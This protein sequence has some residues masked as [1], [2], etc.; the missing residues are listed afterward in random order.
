[1]GYVLLSGP[2]WPHLRARLDTTT[3]SSCN[4]A[5]DVWAVV[6]FSSQSN[7][8]NQLCRDT[9]SLKGVQRSLLWKLWL[10][11]ADG[12][13]VSGA[14][15]VSL[16]FPQKFKTSCSALVSWLCRPRAPQYSLGSMK[17]STLTLPFILAITIWGCHCMHFILKSRREQYV[18]RLGTGR[19][20]ICCQGC[21]RPKPIPLQ[22]YSKESFHLGNHVLD[23]SCGMLSCPYPRIIRTIWESTWVLSD[24]V[25]WL[26]NVPA[27]SVV[28]TLRKLSEQCFR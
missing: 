1:M 16:R 8:R 22:V 20:D 14:C 21:L 4:I 2:L 26:Q 11:R 24:D 18:I 27:S 5:N 12:L 6:A 13:L 28:C 9:V 15:W 7:L 23:K 10:P 19:V 17:L 25:G 3:C